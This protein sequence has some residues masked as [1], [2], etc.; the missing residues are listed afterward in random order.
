MDF[1]QGSGKARRAVSRSA[2][3]RA[4]KEEACPAGEAAGKALVGR[5]PLLAGPFL[6]PTLARGSRRC[7]PSSPTL[8]PPLTL[9]CAPNPCGV[10]GSANALVEMRDDLQKNTGRSRSAR[11]PFSPP[12]SPQRRTHTHAG[13]LSEP[14]GWRPRRRCAGRALRG[15][16]S[17]SAAAR[18]PP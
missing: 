7:I 14:R 10:P 6:L 5:C 18:R 13:R 12:P 15:T 9:Q 1:Q 17:A 3:E 11:P 2:G 8:A 4:R 16:G